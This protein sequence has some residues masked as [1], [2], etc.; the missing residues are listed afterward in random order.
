MNAIFLS[1]L[2]SQGWFDS[3]PAAPKPTVRVVT[4][5]RLRTPS[6]MPDVYVVHDNIRGVTCYITHSAEG[7]GGIFC[8]LTPAIAV[9]KGR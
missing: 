6:G 3:G 8:M 5:E 2:L 9:E 7:G 1:L 4:T